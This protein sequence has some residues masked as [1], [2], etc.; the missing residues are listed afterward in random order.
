[1]LKLKSQSRSSISMINQSSVERLSKWVCSLKYRVISLYQGV[2]NRIFLSMIL[3]QVLNI[4]ALF[5]NMLVKFSSQWNWLFFST[6]ED[7]ESSGIWYMANEYYFMFIVFGYTFHLVCF[8]VVAMIISSFFLQIFAAPSIF[9]LSQL[10]QKPSRLW[11]LITVWTASRHPPTPLLQIL[12]A[13]LMAYFIYRPHD[14]NRCFIC[15]TLPL[16]INQSLIRQL[17]RSAI[18]LDSH[19][20]YELYVLRTRSLQN[21][22]AQMVWRRWRVRGD[23]WR[24]GELDESCW[25]GI[26][27]ISVVLSINFIFELTCPL[28][29]QSFIAMPYEQLNDK[30]PLWQRSLFCGRTVQVSW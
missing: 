13:F 9:Y 30:Y 21:R 6:L 24:G 27:V 19:A 14:E 10:E 26:L 23:H 25:I 5:A 18:R 7:C 22:Q 20:P 3:I 17:H 16:S 4:V 8:E 11:L 1:M 12:Q 15:K 28:S 29:S 2:F